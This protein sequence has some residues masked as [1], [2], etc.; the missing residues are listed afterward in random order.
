LAL[1]TELTEKMIS[2]LPG[3]AVLAAKEGV[4]FHNS[5]AL[6]I[7]GNY[8]E[9]PEEVLDAIEEDSQDIRLFTACR[10]S[11]MLLDVYMSPLGDGTYLILLSRSK[12]QEANPSLTK[13][14]GVLRTP[15]SSLISAFELLERRLGLND[16][17]QVAEWTAIIK[18]SYFRLLRI[19]A[20]LTG[21]GSFEE[22]TVRLNAQ[23]TD[24]GDFCAE[25][26]ARAEG[27]A[28]EKGITISCNTQGRIVLP[29]DR[30]KMER[31]V[32]NLIANSLAHT[33]PGGSVKIT[34]SATSSDALLTVEDNG[35]G[36]DHSSLTAAFRLFDSHDPSLPSVP[37]SGLGLGLGLC[38]KTAELHGGRLLIT[39]RAGKG[40][41]ITV[42]LPLK[43]SE[44]T[45]LY[46]PIPHYD[47]S[48]GFDHTL[49]ELCD[50]VSYKS[51]LKLPSE[52]LSE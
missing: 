27:L 7:L 28:A 4:L 33:P 17:P 1:N 13:I 19:C 31:L 18:R 9:L 32:M 14:G 22:G 37:E 15:L 40:T 34:V 6:Q 24:L 5:I 35:C 38:K 12:P 25:K 26:C 3:A 42:S 2:L 29:I 52:S 16:D 8:L 50:V 39:S 46:S 44:D 49:F 45:R 11:R 51:F 41:S 10:A 43:P 47:Y 30:I 36:M 21:S 48:G 23:T 20:N